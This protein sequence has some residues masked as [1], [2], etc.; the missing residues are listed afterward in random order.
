M[1]QKPVS[2][3]SQPQQPADEGQGDKSPEKKY[4]LGIAVCFGI[5]LALFML[6]RSFRDTAAEGILLFLPL[7]PLVI[8][9]VLLYRV[10]RVGNAGSSLPDVSRDELDDYLHRL[11]QL[12]KEALTAMGIPE[13]TTVVEILP[14]PYRMKKGEAVYAGKKDTYDNTPMDFFLRDGKLHITD[15]E[16]L[17]AIPTHDLVG[18]RT[19]DASYRVEIW[20]K[21]E[22]VTAEKYLPYDIQRSGLFEYR[23]R[24]Y[25]G[26]EIRDAA[27]GQGYELCIPGYDF[28]LLTGLVDLPCLDG[29]T[30]K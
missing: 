4:Y 22:P 25:F 30:S 7:I 24:T 23:T 1:A 6:Y 2:P 14:Y 8:C 12:H 5:A 3:L 19:Y 10:K 18:Y 26:V 9:L 29:E 13:E 28:A 17:Y 27:T 20:L 16:V 15:G 11:D 21:D